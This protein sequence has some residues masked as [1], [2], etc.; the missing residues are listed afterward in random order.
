MT[1]IGRGDCADAGD[2]GLGLRMGVRRG[3]GALSPELSPKDTLSGGGD[4]TPPV[5]AFFM[6]C[7]PLKTYLADVR[8]ITPSNAN[9]CV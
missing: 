4:T 5:G 2:L 9:A 3:S 6:L 8:A 1:I 7:S